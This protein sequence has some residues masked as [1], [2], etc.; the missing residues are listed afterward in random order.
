MALFH[1]QVGIHGERQREGSG[2]QQSRQADRNRL[3]DL[4]V[5]CWLFQVCDFWFWLQC[6]ENAGWLLVQRDDLRSAHTGGVRDEGGVGFAVTHR[7]FC[8]LWRISV[9]DFQPSLLLNLGGL[10][11]HAHGGDGAVSGFGRQLVGALHTKDQPRDHYQ[12][13]DER[14]QVE[15]RATGHRRCFTVG[16]EERAL[17]KGQ[18]A[19]L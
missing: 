1:A 13:D 16:H 11:A 2:D 5:H 18:V 4:V 14:G 19:E 12:T 17:P 15:D 6:G 8:L 7:L 10:L 9:V 3:S